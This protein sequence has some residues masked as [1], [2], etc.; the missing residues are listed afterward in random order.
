MC[1]RYARELMSVGPLRGFCVAYLHVGVSALSPL[2]GLR[3]C[4]G[5]SAVVF[6]WT[7]NVLDI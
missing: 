6:I 2:G 3:G 4:L 7:L 5:S 1:A